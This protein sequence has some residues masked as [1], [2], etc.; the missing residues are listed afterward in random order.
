LSDVRSSGFPSLLLLWSLS[1]FQQSHPFLPIKQGLKVL[2]FVIPFLCLVLRVLFNSPTQFPPMKAG[3]EWCAFCDL[4]VFHSEY[5][6][7]VLPNSY[8]WKQGLSDVLWFLYLRLFTFGLKSIFSTVLPSSTHERVFSTVLPNS[9]YEA[10][11]EWCAALCD[12][13]LVWSLEYFSTV[14][15]NFHL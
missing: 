8:L 4:F 10:G 1:I 2:P 12:S 7:T 15:P 13:F 6:S 11:I 14:P 9:T 5:F 3:I